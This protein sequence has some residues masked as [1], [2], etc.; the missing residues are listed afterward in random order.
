MSIANEIDGLAA[1]T[2]AERD[3]DDD[4]R[5]RT[6]M[7]TS[8]CMCVCVS[9]RSRR[10]SRRL[11][12][13]RSSNWR[14]EEKRDT[15]LRQIDEVLRFARDLGTERGPVVGA[16]RVAEN[17]DARPVVE[18]WNRLHQMRR[19]MVAEVG[20][21]VADA[22]SEIAAAAAAA[23]GLGAGRR[24]RWGGQLLWIFVGRLVQQQHLHRGE[25]HR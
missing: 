11:N 21:D 19:R 2:T 13:S 25:N 6:R 12:P 5:R 8:V 14:G 24:R 16:E 15:D 1:R 20:R 7:D 4:G 9:T 23:A 22:Q 10:R 18:A 3:A 17:L